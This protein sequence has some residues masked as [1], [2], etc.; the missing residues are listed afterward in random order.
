VGL[1]VRVYDFVVFAGIL[2]RVVVCEGIHRQF[3][4]KD[5]LIKFHGLASVVFKA[6]VW[7][8]FGLHSSSSFSI[9][10]RELLF[11]IHYNCV[12]RCSLSFSR[13]STL[14]TFHARMPNTIITREQSMF[15]TTSS[16]GAGSKAPI[17]QTRPTIGSPTFHSALLLPS[18]VRPRA[19]ALPAR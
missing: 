1:Q 19:P 8:Q 14:P 17:L 12:P 5:R 2:R 11:I 13:P 3:A 16:A 9:Y 15:V 7:V 6:Q 4:P 10:V 18:T